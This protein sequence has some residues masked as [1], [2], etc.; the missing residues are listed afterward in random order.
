MPVDRRLGAKDRLN[1][2][3][4]FEPSSGFFFAWAVKFREIFFES[5]APFERFVLWGGPLIS[6][7]KE[8]I[9]Q[10]LSESLPVRLQGGPLFG[11]EALPRGR[12]RA[13]SGR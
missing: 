3:G 13:E 7:F 1:Q 5:R 10:N 11:H 4:V 6:L 9:T 8:G 12:G 2:T